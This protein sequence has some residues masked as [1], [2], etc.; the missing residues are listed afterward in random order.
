MLNHFFNRI[1]LILDADPDVYDGV[2]LRG[3]LDGQAD[4]VLQLFESFYIE[5]VDFLSI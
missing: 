2:L 5:I 3:L 4:Q 1:K